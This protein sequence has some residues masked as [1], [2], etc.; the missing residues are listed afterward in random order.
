M[1]ELALDHIGVAIKDLGRGRA[2]YARLG[3]RLTAYSQHSGSPTPGAPVVPWGSGNHCAMLREGYVE[4]VG[5]THP[6]HY[7]SITAMVERYEGPHIVALGCTNA[8][9]AY[10]ALVAAGVEAD[11]PRALERDAPFG[12]NDESLARAR[13]RNIH[14]DRSAYPEGRFLVIEHLT[15][16]VLWQ[17][18]LLEHPNGAQAL[19]EVYFCT[20]DPV[21]TGS[22][23]GR[24]FG[25]SPHAQG[26]GAVVLA[27]ARGRL[28]AL[29]VADWAERSGA[30]PIAP[31]PMPVGFGIRVASIAR[32]R[33]LLADN[34]VLFKEAGGLWVGPDAA[35]GAAIRFLE[36]N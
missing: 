7:S 8:E 12:K 2:A 10:E 27:L 28:L 14:L 6:E 25:A 22:K 17:P 19:A 16:D 33:A 23:L 4:V 9:L 18:H 13:F 21:A 20:D 30:Q 1:P 29:S 11:R 35:C 34:G 3:F 36:E 26:A 5:L 32:T 24:A 31:L 15:R